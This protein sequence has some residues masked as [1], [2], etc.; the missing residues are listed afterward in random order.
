[1]S[2]RDRGMAIAMLAEAFGVKELTPARI[3]IYD[4]ALSKIPAPVLKPMVDRAITTRRPRYGD[5]PTVADLL[6]DAE[7]CRQELLNGLTFAPCVNCSASGW[8]EV[9]IDGVKRMK[10]CHCWVSHQQ[11]VAELGVGHEPLALPPA[12][13]SEW[14]QAGDVA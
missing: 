10:R 4:E 11:K 2:Q 7:T 5:L 1:M 3:R 9:E 14:T 6:A 8:T 13:E 12:R